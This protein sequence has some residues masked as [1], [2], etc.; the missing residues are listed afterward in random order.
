MTL[1]PPPTVITSASQLAALLKDLSAYP[2]VAVDTESN[3]LYAYHERVCLLQFST[4]EADYVVDP[5]AGLDLAPLGALF[6]D[7]SVQKVFHAAEQDVGWLKRDFGF[8]FANLFDTM[9]AAR[10]LGWPRVGLADILRE[11]FGV[12]TDKRYQRYNW[13]KRPL[14]P[15]ALAYAMLDTHYLLPLRDMQAEALERLDRAEEAAE[16]FA[17]LA[18]TPPATPPFGPDAFWR[19]KGI[20]DLTERE[21][22]VLW[23]LYL[24]R[25]RVA[26]GRDRP[27][28]RVL[29][30][31]ALLALARLRPRRMED[32]VGIKGLSPYL[33]RR[34]GRALLDAVRRG[35]AGR[36]PEPPT[37]SSRP[38]NEVVER[39]HVLRAWRRRVAAR[40]GVDTDV[41][42][43]NAVLWALAER[44]PTTL[45]ELEDI[46]GFGPWKRQTYGEAILRVLATINQ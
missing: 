44:N 30:D 43:P 7:P 29:G 27:P 4:P 42:L 20:H 22:A 31:R 15:E 37:R 35:E 25:D 18:Q 36:P 40:R 34:Y 24:W 9:W 46:P 41:V 32:L 17:Q 16:V 3:S 26:S 6:A 11:V 19:M 21:R 23:E 38:D 14:S 13:G 12:H 10:I 39:Y 8:R 28:F 33:V 1:P 5:M 45:E 2:A